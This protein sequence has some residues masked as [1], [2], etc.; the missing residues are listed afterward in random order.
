MSRNMK[1]VLGIIGG[2]LACCGAAVVITIIFLPRLASNFA[3]ESFIEDP[4][5]VAQIGESIADYELPGGFGEEFAISFAGI[6][7][8]FASSQGDTNSLIMLTSFPQAMEANR[9][10]MQQ[11]ME[12]T[13]RRQIGRQD[14]HLVYKGSEEVVIN[15]ETATLTIY[16]GTD[17]TGV[18][19][20][21]VSAIFE[22]KNETPGMLMI[23]APLD[24]WD[25]QGIDDF[26]SSME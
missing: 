20:R 13:F 19:I 15:G 8:L 17:D 9:E 7:M 14:V 5:A 10:Q 6:N 23:F 3:E 18:D 26:L 4:E 25:E 24:T 21:Q 22:T 1:I 12:Q 16:E 2:L 11:Q